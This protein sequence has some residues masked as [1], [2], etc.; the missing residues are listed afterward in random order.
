MGDV[1][2]VPDDEFGARRIM[3]D[4]RD[5]DREQQQVKDLKRRVVEDY[6]EHIQKLEER[7]G[8][9]RNALYGFCMA[10]GKSV[11]PDVG[12]VFIQNRRPKLVV[13]DEE[14]AL[15][16]ARRIDPSG[17]RGLWR[18]ALAKQE[19]L[20]VAGEQLDQTGELADGTE[21]SGGSS[22][23]SIRSRHRSQRAM[24]T[25]NPPWQ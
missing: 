4:L 19:F 10:H 13:V 3:L 16:C 12:T 25:V 20:S 8:E 17:E 9:L 1:L 2:L 5:I 18:P 14:K 15:E 23:V 6:D 21:M 24:L 11:I 7:K 22:S